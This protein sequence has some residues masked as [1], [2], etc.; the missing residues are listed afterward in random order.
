M[1]VDKSTNYVTVTSNQEKEC[2]VS[3]R[4]ICCLGVLYGNIALMFSYF[5]NSSC[6]V[7]DCSL[8]IQCITQS[9]VDV[10]TFQVAAQF[11]L[12]ISK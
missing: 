2:L 12:A 11:Q 9:W 4:V 10:F 3:W 5:C 6:L 7:E 1:C 8:L